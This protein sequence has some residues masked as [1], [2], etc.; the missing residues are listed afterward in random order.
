MSH[1]RMLRAEKEL[2]KQINVLMRRAEILDAQEDKCYGKGK[3]G[4]PPR[5]RSPRS[6]RPPQP[7]CRRID[8]AGTADRTEQ[9]TLWRAPSAHTAT[10]SAQLPAGMDRAGDGE[11]GSG[12]EPRDACAAN[13]GGLQIS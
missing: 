11:H 13:K 2:E 4:P 5:E 8:A 9:G 10:P 6:A 7:D 12:R 3:L 1:E